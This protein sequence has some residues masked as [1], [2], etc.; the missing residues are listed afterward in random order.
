MVVHMYIVV[1][2]KQFWNPD[3]LSTSFIISDK[4]FNYWGPPFYHLSNKNN[5][6]F[7]FKLVVTVKWDNSNKTAR[8]CGRKNN[9][10]QRYPHLNSQN[11]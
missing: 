10:P 7:H 4:L 11:L 1:P 2:N 3:L 6:N 8:Q 9:G 5:N